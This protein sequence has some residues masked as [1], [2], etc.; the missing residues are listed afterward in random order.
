MRAAVLA[1]L[2]VFAAAP[3]VAHAGVSSQRGDPD[4]QAAA[5]G[6]HAAAHASGSRAS[7]LRP[8]GAT[9]S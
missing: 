2:L 8:P 7:A 3:G 9:G 5:C 4:R 1:A 6:P